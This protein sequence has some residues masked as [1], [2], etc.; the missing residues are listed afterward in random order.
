MRRR[1]RCGGGSDGGSGGGS[2]SSEGRGGGGGGLR[3]GGGGGQRRR[4]RRR[5]RRGWGGGGGGGGGKGRAPEAVFASSF[6]F[7]RSSRFSPARAAHGVSA[8]ARGGRLQ[9]HAGAGAT[10]PL[11]RLRRSR[12]AA[13]GAAV[14]PSD[15][16]RLSPQG[17][18]P[19]GPGVEDTRVGRREHQPP[20]T[21]EGGW[22]SRLLATRWAARWQPGGPGMSLGRR[23]DARSAGGRKPC[24]ARRRRPTC[25]EGPL[26]AS[27]AF[28]LSVA[29]EPVQRLKASLLAQTRHL[30]PKK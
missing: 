3:R 30:R 15:S 20:H 11:A 5:R 24:E 25:R 26:H 21:G 1:R 23:L 14:H 22:Q 8:C 17:G 19:T 13:T 27:G 29:R 16:N 28:L 9:G 10:L 2:G 7:S 18:A 4:R 12:P 6:L